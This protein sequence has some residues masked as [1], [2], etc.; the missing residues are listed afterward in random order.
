M[1]YGLQD[2]VSILFVYW[3]GSC[4]LM[5]VQEG[6]H[7]RTTRTHSRMTC[8]AKVP[9]LEASTTIPQQL[10]VIQEAVLSQ[11]SGHVKIQCCKNHHYKIAKESLL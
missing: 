3:F 8:S 11:V 5:H 9:L 2:N 6:G 7:K 1:T 10:L 4:S